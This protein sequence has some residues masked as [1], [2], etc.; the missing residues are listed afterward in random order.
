MGPRGKDARTARR[1]LPSRPSWDDVTTIEPRPLVAMI[2]LAACFKP[3]NTVRSKVQSR[4]YV[5]VECNAPPVLLT[6]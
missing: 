5:P 3:K 6:R 1:G 4:L 2:A